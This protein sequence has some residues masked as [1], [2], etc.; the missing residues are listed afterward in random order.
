MRLLRFA[1]RRK[2][3]QR[4]IRYAF[5]FM[6][7]DG[8]QLQQITALIEAGI[9]KPVVDR[10]FSFESTTEALQYVEQRRAK[11]KVVIKIK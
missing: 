10:S 11:G 8:A 6:R 1:I 7:A 3:R 5:V 9:I 2:A 4:N